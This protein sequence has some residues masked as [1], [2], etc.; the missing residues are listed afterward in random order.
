MSINHEQ[1]QTLRALYANVEKQAHALRGNPREYSVIT[2]LCPVNVIEMQAQKIQALLVESDADKALIAEQAERIAELECVCA[3]SY[4]VVGALADSLG[5]F[6]DT[7]T[8]K[9]LDNLSAQM[10]VHTDVLPFSVES[11]TLTVKLPESSIGEAGDFISHAEVVSLRDLRNL[12]DRAGI[13]LV[14]GE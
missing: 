8:I 11:S 13:T 14:V 7:K 9:A 10:L 6:N 12:C 5:V 1:I 2:G 4:Q 3:E